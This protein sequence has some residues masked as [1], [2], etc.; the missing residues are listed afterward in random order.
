MR[1]VSDTTSHGKP[2]E[3]SADASRRRTAGTR[4]RGRSWRKTLTI[5]AI[6]L[7]AIAATWRVAGPSLPLGTSANPAAVPTTSH[8][9]ALTKGP[10][11]RT[12]TATASFQVLDQ[13]DVGAQLSGQLKSVEVLPG[14]QVKKGQLLAVIDDTVALSRLAQTRA[15]L[16]S[17][18]AQRAAKEAQ[19]ALA[20]SQRARSAQLMQRG[21]ASTASNE[22]IEATL[23]SLMAERDALAAQE[24]G[25]EAAIAQAETELRFARI[26][27]PMDGT[28]VTVSAKPGQTL[29]TAQQAPV[30]LRIA[31]L[32]SL[33]LVAQASE[34]DILDIR[35]G[36]DVYFTVLGAPGRR[37]SGKVLRILPSPTVLNSVVLYDVLIE[38][39]DPDRTFKLMMTAQVFFVIEQRECAFKLPR[40]SLPRH[41]KQPGP[42][43]LEVVAPN[44]ERRSISVS[45][46]L[47]NDLEAGIDCE[48]ARAAGLS[49]GERLVQMLPAAGNK[50][51]AR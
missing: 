4:R 29:N 21:V 44:G 30:I 51:V 8:R 27:A 11:E 9:Q 20:R 48:V 49:P 18:R 10:I 38:A 34:A 32:N 24:K 50:Q 13:V 23:V 36:M 7:T 25:I 28:V 39:P 26:L 33:Q 42:L 31:D 37:W 6:T 17:L 3:S 1:L 19:I 22:T 2:D 35:P 40:S 45:V 47:V 14:D 46:T 12:V 41:F 5:V 43:N 15:S 16:D